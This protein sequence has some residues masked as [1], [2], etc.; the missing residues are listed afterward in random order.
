MKQLSEILN[1]ML[2]THDPNE[3][4][5]KLID[6]YGEKI[7]MADTDTPGKVLIGCVVPADAE[8]IN[9]DRDFKKLCKY[10]GYINTWISFNCIW[11]ESEFG[12]DTERSKDIVFNQ[13]KGIIYHVC[14]AEINHVS[15][16]KSIERKGLVARN[17]KVDS[18]TGEKDFYRKYSPRVYFFAC[19]E[20]KLGFE[21]GAV[22]AEL[23]YNPEYDEY[24]VVKADISKMKNTPVFR[25]PMMT[26]KY[27]FYTHHNIPP[28]CIVSIEPLQNYI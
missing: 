24:I 4:V 12:V 22:S 18:F 15:M 21:F 7:S 17:F 13:A 8:Y 20:K 6:R 1:E 25:D 27:C 9:D 16:W 3:F 28:K 2:Q 14:K 5:R 23:G 10:Y 19:P 11:C 26:S